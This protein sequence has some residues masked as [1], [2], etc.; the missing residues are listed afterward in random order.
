MTDKYLAKIAE[1][2]HYVKLVL[3]VIAIILVLR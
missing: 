1:Q 2:L 3:T